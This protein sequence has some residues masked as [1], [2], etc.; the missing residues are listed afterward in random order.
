MACDAS[1]I[2]WFVVFIHTVVLKTITSNFCK[3][4]KASSMFALYITLP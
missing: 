4:D 1:I 3:F 2:A